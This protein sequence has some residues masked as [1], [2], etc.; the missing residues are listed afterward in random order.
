ML[1]IDFSC[2]GHR[3][4]YSPDQYWKNFWI[5]M[6]ILNPNM[7]FKLVAEES[8]ISLAKLPSNCELIPVRV[9]KLS[10]LFTG[11]RSFANAV[12]PF[13]E[14][15]DGVWIT[16]QI[17]HMPDSDVQQLLWVDELEWLKF[18]QWQIQSREQVSRKDWQKRSKKLKHFASYSKHYADILRKDLDIPETSIKVFPPFYDNEIKPASWAEKESIKTEYSKGNDFFVFAGDIHNRHHIISLLKA[19]S[20]FKKWQ[21]SSMQ[22]VIMGNTTEHSASILQ[23]IESYKHRDDVLIVTDPK[24]Q[25]KLKI[26]SAAYACLYTAE[27]ISLPETMPYAMMAGVPL[28]VSDIPNMR[29][30]GLDHVL[31]ANAVDETL[32]AEKMILLYKDETLRTRLVENA[33]HFATTL[34]GN[35]SQA[36]LLAMLHSLFPANFAATIK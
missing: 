5:D 29:E 11:N 17:T 24:E 19:Y 15:Q 33:T 4:I 31:Y 34:S 28:I 3:F 2:L 9:N 13:V 26:L 12:K 25:E 1:F 36:S 21:K 8:K 22:L 27:S 20:I 10:G 32:I 23:A 30:W 16:N 35:I 14:G 6:A 7:T 18:P